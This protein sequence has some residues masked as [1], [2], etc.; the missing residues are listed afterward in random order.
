MWNLRILLTDSIFFGRH[1]SQVLNVFKSSGRTMRLKFSDLKQH[2]HENF[3]LKMIFRN[4]IYFFLRIC[5]LRD[6]KVT[7]KILFTHTKWINAL[8]SSS[9]QLNNNQHHKMWMFK[10]LCA[11]N[12][13]EKKEQPKKYDVFCVPLIHYQL[14]FWLVC[15]FG[16]VHEKEQHQ[17]KICITT[18]I[19][20]VVCNCFELFTMNKCCDL[21][22]SKKARNLYFQN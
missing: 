4:Y 7:C 9:L 1:Y 19:G 12:E 2:N 5:S 18:T 21:Y 6:F 14:G 16:L 10:C 17:K 13:R 20:P 8:I 3:R 22:D 15:A 11:F